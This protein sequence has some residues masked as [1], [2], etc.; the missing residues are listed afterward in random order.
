MT[1]LNLV[2]NQKK[3][4][5]KGISGHFKSSE[6]TAIMGPSGSGKSTLLNILTGYMYS[7][8]FNLIHY[9]FVI[10]NSIIEH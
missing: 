10:S 1:N 5:L 8:Y 7:S 9:S 3:T 6:L 2:G 4:I